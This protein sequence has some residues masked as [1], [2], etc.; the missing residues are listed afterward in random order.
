M[1]QTTASLF[2]CGAV[3]TVRGHD[4]NRSMQNLGEDSIKLGLLENSHAFLRP[5]VADALAA[6]TD[7]RKWQ[8]A[9][10]HLVQSLE[11]A[12]KAK[13]H[14]VHP[15]FI[16]E[17]IDKR[18]NTISLTGAL[19]RLQCPEVAGVPLP[20]RDLAD[21]ERVVELRNQITHSQFE[22]KV[23]YAEAKFFEVFAMVARFQAQHLDMEIDQILSTGQMEGLMSIKQ[24]LSSIGAQ[25]LARIAQE[26]RATDLVWSC[27]VCGF[28]SFVIEDGINAC[29]T[30]RHISSVVECAHC[31]QL[32]FEADLENFSDEFDYRKDD[33]RHTLVN[34][35][36][37]SVRSACKACG[38]RI[39][40]DIREHRAS[41]YYDELEE[42]YQLGILPR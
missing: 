26:K 18:K 19:R 17:D 20:N 25:A 40:E 12:V 36:G 15:V 31:G 8:F 6:Q 32:L 37:Y 1:A 4:S 30:C 34:N 23:R 24:A 3:R 33:G 7:T 28:E 13:L 11:L 22:L 41:D 35:Y 39:R 2:L 38:A 9:V 14:K 42:Y 5:A 27:P 16:F 21:I 29:Y 10:L